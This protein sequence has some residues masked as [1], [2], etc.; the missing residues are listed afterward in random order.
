MNLNFDPN[1]KFRITRLSISLLWREYQREDPHGTNPI[2]V[3]NLNSSINN[4][5]ERFLK[6][7]NG[8]IDG[9]ALKELIF[10]TGVNQDFPDFDVFISHSHNDAQDAERLAEVLKHKYG[11][12]PFL[13]KYIWSSADGLLRK[14]DEEYCR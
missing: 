13:D 1:R 14:I 4:I 10:P 11:K 3:Q 7:E 2:L 8:I 9:N 6:P 5:L 12:T